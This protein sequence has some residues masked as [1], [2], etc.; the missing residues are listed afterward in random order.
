MAAR[1]YIFSGRVVDKATQAGVPNVVVEAWD[2][3][4]RFHDML[5]AATTNT[6]GAF[7]IRLDSEYFGDYGGDNAPDVF[8]R[9]YRDRQLIHSTQDAPRMNVPA[10]ETNF[11][12]ELDL[13][14][15]PAQGKDRVTSEQMFKAVTFFH[16]SDFSGVWR[17]QRDK[18]KAGGNLMLSVATSALKGFSFE[19]V[20]VR[21]ARTSEIVG[22]DANTAQKNLAAHQVAVSGVRAF[23]PRANVQTVRSLTSLPK[24]LQAGEKVILYEEN[25]IVRGYEIE[26]PVQASQVDAADVARIDGEV[27]ALKANVTE[28]SRV[29]VEELGALQRQLGELRES[30]AAKD[31][32]IVR[33]RDEIQSGTLQKQLG[34]L[35]QSTAEKDVEISRLKDEVR[36]LRTAQDDLVRRISPE[37]INVLEEQVR[38][39]TLRNPP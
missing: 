23:D 4:T 20:K 15:V 1:E 37:K 17:E 26:R 12:I 29:R 35:R 9:I 19:P 6:D 22:Q 28:L 18:A 33:L 5:G 24:K 39:L 2:L 36:T 16:E 25:G 14:S 11:L 21:G 8:F 30:T 10:G 32:E 3:D 27:S 38:R 31:A 34:E 7:W 13:G